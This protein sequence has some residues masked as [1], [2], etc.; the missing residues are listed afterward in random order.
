MFFFKFLSFLS[1]S[2]N[3]K[4]PGSIQSGTD[5]SDIWNNALKILKGE[6][7]HFSNS[8]DIFMML[9]QATIYSYNVYSSW[10]LPQ[11]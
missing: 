8:L 6:E 2:V 10:R 4:L 3:F 11:I 7:F 1:C 5:Q 9:C